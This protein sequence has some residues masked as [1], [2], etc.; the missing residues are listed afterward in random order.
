MLN[1]VNIF[2]ATGFSYS[3]T[4]SGSYDLILF[5]NGCPDTT[6]IPVIL[7]IASGLTANIVATPPAICGTFATLLTG[8][9]GGNYQW[10][11]NG[12]AI[13]GQTNNTYWALTPG[14]Y[15]L[16]VSSSGCTDTTN[17]PTVLQT[18]PQPQAGFTHV[19]NNGLVTFT[20]ISVGATNYAWT[21][22]D[23]GNS[24]LQNTANVYLTP[25]AYTVTQI[26]SNGPCADTI[27]HVVNIITTKV[28]NELT[29][30]EFEVFPNPNP[31]MF[32]VRLDIGDE[33]TVRVILTNSLAQ[34][35]YSK[36]VPSKGDQLIDI[37]DLPAGTYFLRV[38]AGNRTSERKV[39]RQ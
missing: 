25:G 31:G 18:Y 13:P 21:F 29:E 19:V 6:T 39:V 5:S 14:S 16:E 37:N 15:H 34:E 33:S 26:V 11:L 7:T 9:G 38:I 8:S 22:G 3:A 24:I 12:V 23:G 32:T 20:D 28:D 27:S 10:M 17:A 1:G 36:T 4:T 2:G 35:I 30:Q